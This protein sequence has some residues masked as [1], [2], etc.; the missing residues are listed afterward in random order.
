MTPTLKLRR[1]V[2]HDHFADEIEQ[3]Y[4]ELALAEDARRAVVL[5]RVPAGQA[6]DRHDR[7]G[8]RRVDELV[9]A[10][11]DPDVAEPGEEDEVSRLELR[12]RRVNG[13]RVA[14]LRRRCSAAARRRAA[15][16]RTSRGRSS[17][18]RSGS[19][20][21][22]RTARRGTAPRSRPPRCSGRP[23]DS[24][25]RTPPPSSRHDDRRLRPG[26]ARRAGSRR[27]CA[28]SCAICDCGRSCRG[29]ARRRASPRSCASP[30]RARER[31]GRR[32]VFA[33]RRSCRWRTIDRSY[34][35]T[36]LDERRVLLR[37][38]VERLDPRDEVVE[39][40]GAEDDGEGRLAVLRR[41]DRDEPLRERLL[42]GGEVAA[43]D[44]ERLSCSARAVC[45]TSCELRGRALV[46][47]VR[48]LRARVELLEL[49]GDA[50]CLGLRAGNRGCRV[51]RRD[52]DAHQTC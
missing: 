34:D 27:C 7:P 16:R 36:W 12:P 4:A 19:R 5:V 3:L 51:R 2:I 39:A 31:G 33:W 43:R 40:R 18:S 32:S 14:V 9:V 15:R 6:V 35:V 42:R 17:R 47:A 29:A 49:R 8:V 10:D 25:S 41:V 13:V 50:L 21:P 52:R 23:G 22:R 44:A 24:R 46:A 26:A 48:D 28:S 20:R 11:V 45:W 30:P 37:D 1:R 38:R